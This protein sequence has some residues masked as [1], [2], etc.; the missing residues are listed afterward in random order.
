MT[1]LLHIFVKCLV[2]GFGHRMVRGFVYWETQQAAIHSFNQTEWGANGT[3][4]V[5]S[6]FVMDGSVGA[7]ELFVRSAPEKPT[8]YFQHNITLTHGRCLH[9]VGMFE[10]CLRND[11]LTLD[12][13]ISAPFFEF[14][15]GNGTDI[16]FEL[17]V[18]GWERGL[19]RLDSLLR[20]ARL[21][22]ME[23]PLQVYHLQ[24][25][26]H[27]LLLQPAAFAAALES[28]LN[29]HMKLGFNGTVFY[30]REW[31]IDSIIDSDVV[32]YYLE[33]GLLRIVRW[34]EFSLPS[35]DSVKYEDQAYVY[36]H[37]LLSFWGTNS[38]LLMVDLDEYLA[39]WE[40]STRNVHD[41]LT[42]GCLAPVGPCIRN[43]R[44]VVYS[45]PHKSPLMPHL[46]SG[47]GNNVPQ[48]PASF[49]FSAATWQDRITRLKYRVPETSPEGKPFMDPNRV[50]APFIHEGGI[51]NGNDPEPLLSEG[52]VPL[53][54][55]GGHFYNTSCSTY[56]PCGFSTCTWVM[57]HANMINERSIFNADQ[58]FIDESW[59]WVVSDE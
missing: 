45:S 56:V 46:G 30:C 22:Q 2:K 39:H 27:G 20:S 48:A 38:R 12:D 9:G 34:D 21:P 28:H 41:L 4:P 8:H 37:A 59:H 19:I 10:D 1:G 49:W 43:K 17:G 51:C 13:L 57:H 26:L 14:N 24:S 40:Y 25:P 5:V 16:A 42:T 55:A 32:R 36:A 6:Y 31:Q 58:A 3:V 54:V 7:I 35:I 44:L 29:Y 15:L 33:R 52:G 53:D 47:A 50:F 11:E 23:K 18:R